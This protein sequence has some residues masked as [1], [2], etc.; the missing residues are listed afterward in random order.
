MIPAG[1]LFLALLVSLFV[2]SM[3]SPLA[4]AWLVFFLFSCAAM[5]EPPMHKDGLWKAYLGW[6]IALF[7]AT[8]FLRP[9]GNG[10][11]T[12]WILLAAPM[13]GLAI[14]K[15]TLNKCLIAA[16]TVLVVYA[17][18]LILQLV[19]HVHYTIFEYPLPGREHSFLPRMAYA[20]PLIDPN[21]AACVLNCGLIP[22]F[23]RALRKRL[24]WGFVALFS[25]ALFLTASKAGCMLAVAA[26]TVLLIERFNRLLSAMEVVTV[27]G[28]LVIVS[29][30]F[31]P[32][33]VLTS[34]SSAL[35]ERFPIW[36]AAWPLALRN[37]FTGLGLGSFG[38]YY[39]A[40]RIEHVTGGGFAHNDLLQLAIELGFP[41]AFVF[42][43]LILVVVRATRKSNI[44]SAVVLFTVFAQAMVEF[45]LYVPP[46]SILVGLALAYHRLNQLEPYSLHTAR[47]SFPPTS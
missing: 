41:L 28:V 21:N 7:V 35:V 34:L 30:P 31:W 26:C 16:L 45:Q 17:A 8:F 19:F 23:Y 37:P 3:T 6:I 24:W 32:D 1:L 46:I 43:A 10:A 38:F 11:A 39:S 27:A 22:C 42:L 29:F 40:V 9:V 14:D 4:G 2:Q 18:G 13:L 20:W 36:E 25:F 33:S 5:Y 44:L 47:R 12:M 15:E